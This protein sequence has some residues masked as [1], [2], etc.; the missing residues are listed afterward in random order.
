M[1][2]NLDEEGNADL[3]EQLEALGAEVITR[4]DVEMIAAMGGDVVVG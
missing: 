3:D 4:P 1:R 2:E